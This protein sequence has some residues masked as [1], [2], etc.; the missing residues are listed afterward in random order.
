MKKPMSLVKKVSIGF[1]CLAVGLMFLRMPVLRQ[2]I[3]NTV[4]WNEEVKLLDGRVIIVT[5][6]RRYESGYTGQNFGSVARESWLTIKLPEFDN[7]K[8]TWHEN[9]EAQV[10][11]VYN[12]T[13]YV[14]GIA[15]TGRE[16]D[17][18][19]KPNPAYIGFRYENSK[20]LRIPFEE[21]PI[22]IYDT[23][24]FLDVSPPNKAT[25]VSL[26]DKEKDMQNRKVPM[27]YKK[28]DPKH[29]EY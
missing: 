6:K 16:F 17:M 25:Y 7:K 24:M 13:L 28:I 1:A 19:G 22:E 27:S 15:P 23:N 20:W 12:G 14:V 9:L 4:T 8:I 29:Q 5:Q 10:M 26:V 3:F 18:Y 11:N 21:I 2:L